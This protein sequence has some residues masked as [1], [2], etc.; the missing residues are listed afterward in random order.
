MLGSETMRNR[1]ELSIA[2]GA[3]TNSKRISTFIEGVYPSHVAMG[4]G[5]QLISESGKVYVDFICGLGS[6]I[7]GYGNL[8]VAEKVY[9]R[10]TL[11]V[12]LSLS[13]VQ[14]VLFAEAIKGVFPYVERLRVLKSGSEGCAAAVK[15]ARAH[16]GR[17]IVLSSGYHGWTDDFV[18]LTPPANGVPARDWMRTLGSLEDIS[19]EVAAVIVEPVITSFNS[20][21]I[22]YLQALRD[23][24]TKHGAVLIFDE[25]ITACRFPKMSVANHTG[26]YPDISV[27]GKALANGLPISVVGGKKNILESDYFVS[28][29]FAGDTTAM[30][31]ALVVLHELHASQKIDHLWNRGGNFVEQF[32]A[33]EGPV[34]I[35]G[36]N[37]RGILAGDK[38]DV[39]LFM[40]ETC[41][42]G[43]IFGPSWFW[44]L[45]H[46]DHTDEVIS[47]CR[48]IFQRM[49]DGAVKLEGRPSVKPFAQKV[50]E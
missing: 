44:A 43:I 19:S 33:L 3:L 46:D 21:Q 28:S 7:L 16:T 37:T 22:K 4:K 1:A 38:A 47:T 31:A 23:A 26:I 25:T 9:K 45:P 24:C 29:T 30:A 20:D 12:T 32:N 18:S 27:F 11:G 34:S 17:T 15:M 10:M 42:A 35:S 14:E 49:K 40:Q 6:N 41:K 48:S 2:H 50:R 13:S 5:C 36:Y 39:D 8:K